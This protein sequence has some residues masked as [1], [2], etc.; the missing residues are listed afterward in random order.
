MR[1]RIGTTLCTR[2][3]QRIGNGIILDIDK[4]FY[5]VKTDFGNIIKLTK[6][7]IKELYRSGFREYLNPFEQI[8][9]Q[10]ELLRKNFNF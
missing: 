6:K 10:F 1:L 2:N 3:G 5:I 7:E 4:P 8:E 9:D